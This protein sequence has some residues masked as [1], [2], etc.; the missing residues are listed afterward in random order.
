MTPAEIAAE[1]ISLIQDEAGK[2]DAVGQR[3][4]A[5]RI[6]ECVQ[7]WLPPPTV[8]VRFTDPKPLTTAQAREYGSRLMEYGQYKGTPIKDVPH[9]YLAWLA[10][11]SRE[12][13]T[14]LR[15]YLSSPGLRR[16][17]EDDDI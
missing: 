16:V 4:M 14:S 10:D 1:I 8:A 2:L 17:E 5:R 7:A 15:D 11:K 12:T 6:Q 13:W 3:I 9:D